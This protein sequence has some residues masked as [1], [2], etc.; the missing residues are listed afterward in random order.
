MGGYWS[1]SD[2]SASDIDDVHPPA[3]KNRPGQMARRAIW[4]KKFG[5]KANHITSGQGAVAEKRKGREKD[6]GWDARRGAKEDGRGNNRKE[7]RARG[8]RRGFNGGRGAGG[9]GENSQPLGR[10]RGMGKK[11]DV[12]VLHPSW[13]AAKKA[14]EEKSK[15]TF[16]GKKVTFD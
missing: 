13:Q 2:S 8:E 4:E 3:R 9:T 1:G 12:G 15:A 16:Q 11:D 14:K 6:D 7:R 5:T 10:K